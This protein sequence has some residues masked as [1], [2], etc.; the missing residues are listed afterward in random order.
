MFIEWESGVKAN[1]NSE[2]LLQTATIFFSIEPL[3]KTGYWVGVCHGGFHLHGLP[4]AARSGS[5][6]YKMKNSCPQR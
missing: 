1:M 4:R 3:S 6:N 5:E 2:I